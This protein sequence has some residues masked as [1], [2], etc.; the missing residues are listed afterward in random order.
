MRPILPNGGELPGE[1]W[2]EAIQI[3]KSSSRPS[4]THVHPL[5][6]P[7]INGI[8]YC[9]QPGKSN[10]EM[11]SI[12]CKYFEDVG[13]STCESDSGYINNYPDIS[14]VFENDMVHFDDT[15]QE[16]SA[17]DNDVVL[18]QGLSLEFDY[19]DYTSSFRYPEKVRT[20]ANITQRYP[21]N[22]HIPILYYILQKIVG[23]NSSILVVDSENVYKDL[24]NRITI[25]RVQKALLAALDS[26]LV[27]VYQ[28]GTLDF[29]TLLS[30]NHSKA[31]NY[32]W[33][34]IYLHVIHDEKHYGVFWLYVG[35]GM[36]VKE[37]IAQH[38]KFRKIPSRRCL[39]YHIWNVDNR[40]DFFVLLAGF[41]GQSF[42]DNDQSA[43]NNL[44]EFWSCLTWQTLPSSILSIALPQNFPIH[45][46]NIHL[47][48]ASPLRQK[49]NCKAVTE[50]NV[51]TALEL[52]RGS[53][54][55]LLSPD[56]D[57]VAYFKQREG[58]YNLPIWRKLEALQLGRAI[59][60]KTYFRDITLLHRKRKNY[61]TRG[62]L[63]N[64]D[65]TKGDLATVWIQCAN[66]KH[67]STR[68][69]DPAPIYEIATGL[70]VRRRLACRMCPI[71]TG[72]HGRW[73]GSRENCP[74][75][76]VDS[77]FKS[78]AQEAVYCKGTLN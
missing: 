39:H 48:R 10:S 13:P 49:Y 25:D 1:D 5:S 63:M 62:L 54:S 2:I 36:N 34:G 6:R 46:A 4:D 30:L 28:S 38:R 9:I 70:Y 74:T 72:K 35:A 26:E 32:R 31:E 65:S 3:V 52:Y 33:P 27:G 73:E 37:R 50:G 41:K 19:M 24:I 29:P 18:S 7:S 45:E 40:R 44:M 69:I 47:N 75:E 42:S 14:I 58:F 11:Y 77:T 68:R 53:Q 23:D 71:I 12:N 15:I 43:M 59:Q 66:C 8:K 67:P 57:I 76:P 16:N 22:F 64:A 17:L 60:E 20:T 78:V 51:E 21:E 61:N 56:P 55:L